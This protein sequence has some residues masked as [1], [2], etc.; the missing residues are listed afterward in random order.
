MKVKNVDVKTA[1]TRA[2]VS[3]GVSTAA[4]RKKAF[5]AAPKTPAKNPALD[6]FRGPADPI[7]KPEELWVA[8]R[9][10]EMT[11][12]QGGR[13][14]GKSYLSDNPSF[15]TI[16]G[17]LKN[18]VNAGLSSLTPYEARSLARGLGYDDVGGNPYQPNVPISNGTFTAGDRVALLVDNQIEY[19][20]VAQPMSDGGAEVVAMKNQKLGVIDV[21]A[22]QAT[23]IA[24]AL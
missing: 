11:E 5:G 19:G 17:D 10:V 12:Q 4:T 18:F 6:T 22:S 16:E 13:R 3:T 24:R 8:W 7:R 21:K 14:D 9:A 2:S 23:V 1:S 15:K 20:I